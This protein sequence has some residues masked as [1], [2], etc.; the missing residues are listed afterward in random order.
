M[1]KFAFVSFGRREFIEPRVDNKT[2]VYYRALAVPGELR[3]LAADPK[4]ARITK[5]W[6]SNLRREKSCQD[7][8]DRTQWIEGAF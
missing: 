1:F 4:A 3:S 5:T 6:V 8:K 7:K 2:K